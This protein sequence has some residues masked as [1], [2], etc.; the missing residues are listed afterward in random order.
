MNKEVLKL[1]SLKQE[2][3]PDF[4]ITFFCPILS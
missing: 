3:T 1:Q 2:A 4:T